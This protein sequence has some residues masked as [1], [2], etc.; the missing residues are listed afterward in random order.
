MKRNDAEEVFNDIYTTLLEKQREI[1]DMVDS[2]ITN[3]PKNTPSTIIQPAVDILDEDETVV[4]NV[5][6]PG[7]E[8]EKIKLDITERSIELTAD[9]R[10]EREAEKNYL[11]RE[12]YSEII[13]RKISLPE[14]LDI[15]NTAAKFEGG[16]LSVT[17]PKIVE[18]PMEENNF[19]V[20]VD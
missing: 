6:L 9:Y 10:D 7:I 13:E 5:D 11:T 17:I 18:T 12:R 4:V 14:G 8:R 15:N 19:E 1:G 20:K 3:T 16:V 2:Y